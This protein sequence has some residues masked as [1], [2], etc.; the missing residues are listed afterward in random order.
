[1]VLRDGGTE[2]RMRSGREMEGCMERKRNGGMEDQG[3]DGW[4]IGGT[5]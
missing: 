3:M 2:G 5:D 4:S 1:M